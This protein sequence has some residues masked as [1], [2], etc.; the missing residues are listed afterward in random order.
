M[1]SQN[2]YMNVMEVDTELSFFF[3]A[4]TTVYYYTYE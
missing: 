3:H 2:E 1:Y 4:K